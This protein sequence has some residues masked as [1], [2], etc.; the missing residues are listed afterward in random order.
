MNTD[1]RRV[2]IVINLKLWVNSKW[3]LSREEI[4][5]ARKPS[6]LKLLPAN[7]K[8]VTDRRFLASKENISANNV[9]YS[10]SWK[11]L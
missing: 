10:Y 6:I 5:N 8:R 9:Y 3:E 4:D 2:Q 7:S 1:A 11:N